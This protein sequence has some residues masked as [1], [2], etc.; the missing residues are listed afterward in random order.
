MHSLY[1]EDMRFNA[2]SLMKIELCVPVDLKN[3]QC[4]HTIQFLFTIFALFLKKN[5]DIL[6]LFRNPLSLQK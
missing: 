1:P 4:D 6:V 2:K 3:N 5:N